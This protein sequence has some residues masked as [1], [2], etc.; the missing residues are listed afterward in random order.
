MEYTLD[1]IEKILNFK[2]WSDKKKVDE[3]L[4]ID[5]WLYCNLGMDSS[6]QEKLE[7]R[8]KSRVIYVKI[9]KINPLMGEMFLQNLDKG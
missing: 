4:R 8:K 1:G 6:K 9:K 7:V 3:L 5:C 2:T